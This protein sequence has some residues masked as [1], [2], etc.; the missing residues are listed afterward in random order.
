MILPGVAVAA[1]V[2]VAPAVAV[3]VEH[4]V[5]PVWDAL[6]DCESGSDPTTDTGNGYSGMLQW[7]PVSWDWWRDADDPLH[8]A[9]ATAAQEIA[10]AER[11]VAWEKDQGRGGFG[12]WP[13]CAR[14]LGLPR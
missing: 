4:A 10:A 12:P 3:P 8:A 14:K 5:P 13:A 11:Y 2:W 9:D 1:V 7:S 6:A